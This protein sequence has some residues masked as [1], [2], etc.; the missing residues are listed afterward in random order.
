VLAGVAAAAP[1]T[2]HT[3]RKSP[4]GPIEAIAQD[5]NL[6][7]W[8]TASSP[9][10]CDQ[11]HVLA[12]GKKDRS[13]PPASAESITCTWDTTAGQPQLAIAGRISMALWTLHGGPPAPFDYVLTAPFVGG[14]EQQVDRL[15]HASDGTGKWLEGVAG[16]GKTL[17]YSWDDV[18][19]VD[20]LGCLSG[21]SCKEKIAA[22]GIQ[23]VTKTG[24][25]PLAGALPALE[26]AAS[27]G[28][29]AYIPAM[30]VKGDH[31]APNTNSSLYVADA[32]SGDVV[33]K[34]FVHGIP[35]AIALSP[36]VLAVLTTQAGPHDRISWFAPI[37]GKK[38]G[39][40]LISPR[41]APEL[42]ASDQL[43]V[44][45]VNRQ[46]YGVSTHGGRPRQLGK[47]GQDSVGLS[48][49][50]GRLAWADNHGGTGRLRAVSVG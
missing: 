33:G 43:I 27:A 34:A 48:L 10:A 29:I 47:T 23:V 31:P 21:G 1:P 46:L 28:R 32:S 50:R 20:K 40:V 24:S 19:Y 9:H 17:A 8:F 25:Q 15:A 22:G 41:A 3:L 2:A 44:F 13:F 37:G 49:A 26:L 4:T 12:P 36:N 30:T 16:A 35:L 42:A 38:L 14:T 7:A 11:V 18:E 45:R 39:S 6:A 5:N